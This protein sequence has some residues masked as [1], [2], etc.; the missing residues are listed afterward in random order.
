MELRRSQARVTVRARLGNMTDAN[1]CQSARKSLRES[2]LTT[3]RGGNQDEP[4]REFGLRL[5]AR[6]AWVQLWA[7]P[8][9]GRAIVSKSW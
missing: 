4:V 9:T 1:R 2:K 5:L 6:V 8:S 7:G 3:H